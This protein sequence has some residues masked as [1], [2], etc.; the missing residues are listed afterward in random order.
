M[1][2]ANQV[3]Q[4]D[5]AS[6]DDA[7]EYD[8]SVAAPSKY[9]STVSNILSRHGTDVRLIC[10]ETI[11]TTSHLSK[12]KLKEL[13]TKQNNELFSWM[14][15]TDIPLLDSAETIFRRYGQEIPPS[16]ASDGLTLDPYVDSSYTALN[17][18]VKRLKGDGG[19]MDVAEQIKWLLT[20][21][22]MLGEEVLRL[23]L[24]LF[25]KI[26]T[27]D[28]LHQRMPMITTLSDNDA[29][30]DLIQSFSAY[31]TR[32]YEAS[33]FKETYTELMEGYKKWQICRQ[34]LSPTQMMRQD[35]PDPQCSICLTDSVGYALVPCG[36]TFCSTCTKKQNTTC[37]IC[38]TMI[39][40]RMKLFFG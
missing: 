15:K 33:Q 16:S 39:K 3:I 30:P 2:R 24:V 12:K 36:H 27:L 10:E 17:E 25:N 6:W 29:L 1:S 28:K 34:L 22:K 38:R 23:E 19:L 26:E 7:G 9:R 4:A 37:Y 32:V 35:A 13:I 11:P 31:A 20:Q 40:E 21:Y 18:G 5:F 8:L 14:V